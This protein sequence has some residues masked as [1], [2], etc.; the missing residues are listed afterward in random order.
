MEKLCAYLVKSPKSV[1]FRK[2]MEWDGDKFI[3]EGEFSSHASIDDFLVMI[4]YNTKNGPEVTYGTSRRRKGSKIILEGCFED[5]LHA[6]YT[7]A[8]ADL[9]KLSDRIYIF[10]YKANIIYSYISDEKLPVLWT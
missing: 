1:L 3:C 4:G 5:S 2:E 10:Q 7:I 9:I 8:E 6:S